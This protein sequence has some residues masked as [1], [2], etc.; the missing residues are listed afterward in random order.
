MGSAGSGGNDD[1]GGGG[2]VLTLSLSVSMEGRHKHALGW[3]GRVAYL[4]CAWQYSALS[5]TNSIEV[6][7][8]RQNTTAIHI[9][10]EMLTGWDRVT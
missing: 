1:D 3:R 2:G 8:S 9:E 4:C 7:S 5:S 6:G 10:L